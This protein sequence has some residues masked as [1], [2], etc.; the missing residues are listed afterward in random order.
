M[1]QK[2]DV[3]VWQN[4]YSVRLKLIDEQHQHL[5]KLTN[6]LFAACMAGKEQTKT[7]FSETIREAIDYVGYHFGTE[8]KLMERIDYPEFSK[9]KQEHVNF[10]K[11]VL[12]KLE[13]Y[14]NGKKLFAPLSFVYFLR[15]WI[16]H[17]VAVSDKKMGDYLL[18]LQKS[19][20]LQR[21]TVKVKRDEAA[22]RV[23]IK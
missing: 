3:V 8:E 14:T 15:D 10:V 18:M 19:G 12:S 5:I 6:R 7:V 17:H 9:H 2:K 11:E 4:S 21:M 23:Y 16:L 22:N 20:E 1:V 13:E